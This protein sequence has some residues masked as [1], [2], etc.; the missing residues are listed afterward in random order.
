MNSRSVNNLAYKIMFRNFYNK[1]DAIH[2]PTEFIRNVFETICGTTNGY[3]ISNGVNK[4]FRN[5]EISK[6]LEIKDKYIILFTG[7]YSKEKSHMILLKAVTLLQEADLSR[8][9]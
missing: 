1:V 4:A 8:E 6:P 9:N 5:K 3:V 2:Y 7:R